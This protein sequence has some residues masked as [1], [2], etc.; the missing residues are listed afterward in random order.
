MTTIDRDELCLGGGGIEMMH[1]HRRC[2]QDQYR[3]EVGMRRCVLACATLLAWVLL[4]LAPAR[5]AVV[6]EVISAA[7]ATTGGTAVFSAADGSQRRELG[8]GGSLSN[9]FAPSGVRLYA[10]AKEVAA[11]R[12][13][14]HAIDEDCTPSSEVALNSDVRI[15]VRPWT[16][17]WSPSGS[18]IAFYATATE[19]DLLG[20]VTS[21]TEG[22]F[23]GMVQRDA[24]SGRPQSV[25]G[26][27]LALR[28]S[29]SVASWS[30]DEQRVTFGQDLPS[31]G[32]V[33]GTQ[34][35]VFLG[36]VDTGAVV[37]LTNSEISE[38]QP[39]FSPTDNHVAYVSRTGKSGA[40]RN[41]TF[42]LNPDTRVVSQ[43]T[44]KSN[45]GASQI[46]HPSYSPDGRH[47]VFS[48]W[49]SSGGANIYRLAADGSGR[50]VDLTRSSSDI[51]Y[52]PQWRR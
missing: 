32:Y 39:T 12:F 10:F 48:G 4:D 22:L 42:V 45:A 38:H 14:L 1:S 7:N 15:N 20:R 25:L 3:T 23:V 34:G 18:R 11:G 24:A 41:D 50:A 6:G 44:N 37:N 29:P 28:I 51:H 27:R 5:A 31:N 17:S 52:V 9:A 26:V 16:I 36:N 47:I 35:D 8:C 13:A 49:P 46:G 43:L 30:G 40:Y 19:V 21:T 2:N 33:S